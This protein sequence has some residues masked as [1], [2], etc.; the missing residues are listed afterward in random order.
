[1]IFFIVLGLAAPKGAVLFCAHFRITLEWILRI[2][3]KN[4]PYD[5]SW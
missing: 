4:N 2:F 5:F 1:M 3:E